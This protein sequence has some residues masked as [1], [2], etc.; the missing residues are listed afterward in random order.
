ML[1]TGQWTTSDADQAKAAGRW[2]DHLRREAEA[3]EA[4]ARFLAAM[5]AAGNPGS[6]V[7]PRY[8][9]EEM[10]ACWQIAETTEREPTEAE[11]R[12]Q[13]P[14][15][16]TTANELCYPYRQRVKRG[17]FRRVGLQEVLKHGDPWIS[18]WE[19]QEACER[20]AGEHGVSM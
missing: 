14:W 6:R 20:I 15:Y 18:P 8:P 16:L 9:A 2:E 3:K 13:Q 7:L 11:H 10:V 12:Y 19:I 4:L 1:Q 17:V 5:S